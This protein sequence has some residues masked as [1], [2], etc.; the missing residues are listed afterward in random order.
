MVKT[1]RG[2]HMHG[3]RQSAVEKS[4]IDVC[5]MYQP[6]S[7]RSDRKQDARSALSEL[8][9]PG[10]FGRSIERVALAPCL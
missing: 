8:D 3:V 4:S 7:D 1:L 9:E 10:S 2:L 5:L 6:A